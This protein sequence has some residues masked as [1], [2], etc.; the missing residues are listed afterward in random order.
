M[1]A[2]QL[3]MLD[4]LLDNDEDK[5]SDYDIEFIEDMNKKRDEILTEKQA[6]F[7]EKIWGEIMINTLNNL[8]Q[9]ILI[10]FMISASICLLSVV[11]KIYKE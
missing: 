6:D 2:K 10:L 1:D 5:L 11:W 8:T 7:L 3:K 4:E 9:L